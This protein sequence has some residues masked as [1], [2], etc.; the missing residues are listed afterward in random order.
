VL[1]GAKTPETALSN[2]GELPSVF[3]SNS[4]SD[5]RYG[6]AG[7]HSTHPEKMF[8]STSSLQLNARDPIATSHIAHDEGPPNTGSEWRQNSPTTYVGA[9][10]NVRL[11][12]TAVPGTWKVENERDGTFFKSGASPPLFSFTFS[13]NLRNDVSEHQSTTTHGTTARRASSINKVFH[14]P[15]L[16]QLDARKM[17]PPPPL[18]FQTECPANTG[19]VRLSNEIK[20]FE[21]SVGWLRRGRGLGAWYVIT[22]SLSR[23]LSFSSLSGKCDAELLFRIP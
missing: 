5:P 23:V 8:Y 22:V 6:T 1:R 10:C 15:H 12:N 2:N 13:S 19:T 4:G 14:T 16:A 7:R 20:G 21:G 17:H 3:P 11:S 18:N 9:V